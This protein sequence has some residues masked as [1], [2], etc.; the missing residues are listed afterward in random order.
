MQLKR[1][2]FLKLAGYGVTALCV[3]PALARSARAQSA[4]PGKVLV[5]GFMQGGAD[6]LSLVVPDGDAYY[7]Q[8]RPTIAIDR[9]Y[10]DGVG[11]RESLPA[12]SSYVNPAN[13]GMADYFRLHP[14]WSRLQSRFNAGEL[15]IVHAVGVGEP[16]DWISY[17]HFT[18]VDVIERADPTALATGWLYRALAELADPL[19]GTGIPGFALSGRLIGSLVGPDQSRQIALSSL[20]GFDLT[21]PATGGNRKDLLTS[22]YDPA[23]LAGWST[24]GKH[25][26]DLLGGATGQLFPLIDILSQPPLGD[27]SFSL[28]GTPYEDTT[29]ASW[30]RALRDAA[31]L[32]KADADGSLGVRVIAIDLSGWDH[33]YVLRTYTDQRAEQLDYLLDAFMTDLGSEASRTLLLTMTEFGRTAFENGSRGTDHGFGTLMLAL[34][35]APELRGQRIL[36]REQDDGSD[37]IGWPGVGPAPYGSLH[38]GAVPQYHRDIAPSLI[39]QYDPKDRDL[40]VTTDFRDVFAEVLE[41]WESGITLTGAD[42]PLL[43]Y[44]P[45]PLPDGGLFV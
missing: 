26:L 20:A 25:A 1:R 32:I 39:A 36:V 5:V 38:Q 8:I 23:R 45:T 35:G 41:W 7:P 30:A 17:S 34:S 31:A 43:D 12:T 14:N 21:P 2:E 44:V 28:V 11:P 18:A 10:Y 6:G 33:H 27:L 16:D 15:A 22:I 24:T 13:S 4:S 3:P 19:P 29:R 40:A 42:K 37:A 9:D